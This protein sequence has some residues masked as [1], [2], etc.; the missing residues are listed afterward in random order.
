M[1]Y[2]DDE[3]HR[4]I[5]HGHHYQRGTG[6][7]R[8]VMTKAWADRYL[9]HRGEYYNGLRVVYLDKE[10]NNKQL[11]GKIYCAFELPA[12]AANQLDP[13]F[14]DEWQQLP[15]PF[16]ILQDYFYSS[17]HCPCHRKQDAKSLGAVVDPELLC[18]GDRFVIERITPLDQPDLILLSEV[19]D[20]DDFGSGKEE[21]L[22]AMLLAHRKR[23]EEK[24]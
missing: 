2:F 8:L 6:N 21:N 20:V 14:N 11:V 12:Y 19:Y 22:E 13:V 23:Q 3:Q 16:T 4:Q 24:S 9:P 5:L 1:N 18:E 7:C 17:H 10:D 15:G